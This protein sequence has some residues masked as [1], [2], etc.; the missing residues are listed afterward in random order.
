VTAPLVIDASAVVEV[1]LGTTE[2]LAVERTCG[3]Y[4]LVA[5]ECLDPEVLHALRGLERGRKLQARRAK[6][7]VEDLRDAA[8]ARVAHR[9]LL[10]HAWR[11]RHNLSAY[12][13]MYVA[14]AQDLDCPLVT[15]DAG[16]LGAPDLGVTVIRPGV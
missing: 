1:L 4:Q 11:L 10:D 14:L 9:T 5:P 6:E 15:L 2:G 13:A 8:I 3:G 16:I 7:A 12:D